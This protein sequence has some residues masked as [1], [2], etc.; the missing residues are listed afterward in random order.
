MLTPFPVETQ[1][2][3]AGGTIGEIWARWLTNL[4]N[5]VNSTAQKV[6][7]S[8][9]TASTASVGPT[10]IATPAKDGLYR[11]SY[12]LRVTRPATISS[13]ATATFTW[14]DGGVTQS[15]SGS[16]VT[17]NTT[18]SQQGGQLMIGADAGTAI[19]YAIAYASSGATPM[20]YGFRLAVEQLP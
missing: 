15:Q 9:L 19:T 20:Q 2:L 4:R 6:G 13:S 5:A 11:L 10:T 3:R 8:T 16:A 14:V 1:V 7:G 17:G 12:S 18:T